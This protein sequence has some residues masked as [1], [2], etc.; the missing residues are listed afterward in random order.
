MVGNNLDFE[1]PIDALELKIKGLE[2]SVDIDPEKLSKEVNKL[3]DAVITLTEKIYSNL[4]LW[5]TVQVAR[6]PNRPHI[7]EYIE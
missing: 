3:N 5:Q 6:H 7:Y 1:K 4:S 2:N